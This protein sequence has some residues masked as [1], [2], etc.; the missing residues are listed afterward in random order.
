[1]IKSEVA[2]DVERMAEFILAN[3]RIDFGDAVGVRFVR[4]VGM[5]SNC[6]AR[7]YGIP[8]AIK[9]AVGTNTKY[10]VEVNSSTYDPLPLEEKFRVLLHEFTHIPGGARGS[11]RAHR[12]PFFRRNLR[13]EGERLAKL[14][15]SSDGFRHNQG[16]T[17]TTRATSQN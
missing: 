12:S 6:Y 3:S 1:M 4:S 7:I 17:Q 11:L 14:Y 15:V 2:R 13:A 5:R 8:A 9:T 10:V 16:I